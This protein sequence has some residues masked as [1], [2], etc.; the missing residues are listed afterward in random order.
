MV[1]RSHGFLC[2]SLS[3]CKSRVESR[4][5]CMT[6]GAENSTNSLSHRQSGEVKYKHNRL[7]I[8]QLGLTISRKVT[9]IGQ[10]FQRK[11]ENLRNY[12][13]FLKIGAFILNT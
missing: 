1:E 3:V 13:A 4:A 7:I 11:L 12:Y 2:S 10:R 5:Q 8:S 6:N 9:K